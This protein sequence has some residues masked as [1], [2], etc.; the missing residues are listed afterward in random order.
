MSSDTTI[1]NADECKRALR[2]IAD[3][4]VIQIFMSLN[5]TPGLRFNELVRIC[6]TNAVTLKRRLSAL[7]QAKLIERAE[8]T[9]DRQSVLYMLSSLG[10]IC[11]PIVDSI[12][13]VS[14]KLGGKDGPINSR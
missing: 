2:L 10:V 8:K 11:M 14:V 9:V 12:I 1:I 6:N 3:P 7:E 13:A 5:H 4:L